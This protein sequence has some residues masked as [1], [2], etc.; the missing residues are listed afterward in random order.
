MITVFTGAGVSHLGGVLSRPSFLTRPAED[1]I[2]RQQLIERVVAEWNRWHDIKDGTP[3][4]YL[5][6]T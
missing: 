3:E 2:S 5:G 6:G 4:Q 1:R